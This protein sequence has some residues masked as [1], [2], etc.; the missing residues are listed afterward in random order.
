MKKSIL[1]TIFI[2][3]IILS[4]YFLFLKSKQV[5]FSADY[6]IEQG[7]RLGA[8]QSWSR[9]DNLIF[10]YK[11]KEYNLTMKSYGR[12]CRPQ[13]TELDQASLQACLDTPDYHEINETVI[14]NGKI[15]IKGTYSPYRNLLIDYS[16]I[17]SQEGS[18]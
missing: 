9:N 13:A 14:E 2:L 15:K 11:G 6:T 18:N 4:L 7:E 1:I 12:I 16:A 8:M 10:L 17:K 3:L 5:E